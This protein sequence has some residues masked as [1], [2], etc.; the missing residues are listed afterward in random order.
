[1]LQVAA[2]QLIYKPVDQFNNITQLY[3]VWHTNRWNWHASFNLDVHIW[4][5]PRGGMEIAIQGL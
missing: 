5:A 1:M 2:T 4:F 3:Q